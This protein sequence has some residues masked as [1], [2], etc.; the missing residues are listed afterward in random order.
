MA[1]ERRAQGRRKIQGQQ[2]EPA[3]VFDDAAPGGKPTRHGIGQNCGERAVGA[4]LALELQ[5]R[6]GRIGAWIRKPLTK[7]RSQCRRIAQA[8]VQT[9]ACDGVQRLQGVADRDDATISGLL[10]QAECERECR[11]R[12]LDRERAKPGAKGLG[13]GFGKRFWRE[14]AKRLCA[15]GRA[16]PDD[17]LQPT[18]CRVR[19]DRE[20]ALIGEPFEGSGCRPPAR[21][22][23]R[24]GG[25][26]LAKA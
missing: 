8:K 11:N 5:E 13:K 20:R 10:A 19:Q 22:C 15:L 12:G 18:A 4:T 1:R 2:C 21:R 23:G 25:F 26:R 3:G 16:A 24:A 14:R 7:R 9:L 17:R 6:A